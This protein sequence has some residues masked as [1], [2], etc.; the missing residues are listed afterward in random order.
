MSLHRLFVCILA[1][2]AATTV[3]A[4]VWAFVDADGVPR[5]AGHQVDARYQLFFK[6][7]AA[8]VLAQPLASPWRAA[9]PAPPAAD[10]RVNTS[11]PTDSVVSA[12]AAL[13]PSVRPR[14]LGMLERSPSYK[15]V[16]PLIEETARQLGLDA[17]L[18]VALIAA[19]SGF[20]PRA[21]SPKGATGLMQLMP[22]T[23]QRYGVGPQDGLSQQERL[24][25]PEVNL[26]AGAAFLRDLLLMFPSRLDL[27]L[28]AYNAG[29]GAVQRAGNRVPNYPETQNYVR[30]VTDLLAYLR[31]PI[32]TP[33]EV[34]PAAP[35][36]RV[37]PAAPPVWLPPQMAGA[38]ARGILLP[39]AGIALP[40]DAKTLQIP[41]QRD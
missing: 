13:T 40:T 8:E 7:N 27:A 36:T 34:E 19:E 37:V 14:L 15:R 28:A 24:M 11:R 22:G 32:L 5:F 1:L 35:V 39:P 30:V 12:V 33:A 29:P 25:Q 16:L 26:R 9:G 4:E 6:G 23:A 18:M 17:N 10:G 20:N 3:R 2:L 31:P 38:V 41:G 21:V